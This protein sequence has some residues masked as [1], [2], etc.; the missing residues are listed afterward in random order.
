MSKE[1]LGAYNSTGCVTRGHTAPLKLRP[2]GAIN[3]SI[4][5]TAFPLSRFSSLQ[6]AIGPTSQLQDCYTIHVNSFQSRRVIFCLM[7]SA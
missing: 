7:R 5:I 2:N 3:K 4:I 1:S 6:N